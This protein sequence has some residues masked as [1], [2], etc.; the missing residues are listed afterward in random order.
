MFLSCSER[1]ATSSNTDVNVYKSQ[2]WVCLSNSKLGHHF[3]I[4]KVFLVIFRQLDYTSATPLEMA[5]DLQ[6]KNYI[7]MLELQYNNIMILSQKYTTS[8]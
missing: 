4:G 1:N 5:Q 7:V 6:T 3:Q 8:P 2:Q